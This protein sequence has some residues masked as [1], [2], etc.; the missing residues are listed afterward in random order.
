MNDSLLLDKACTLIFS[1]HHTAVCS[2]H[3]LL[4]FIIIMH[5]YLLINLCAVYHYV[6]NQLIIV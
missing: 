4:I 5:G 1:I 6:H 3:S 2:S